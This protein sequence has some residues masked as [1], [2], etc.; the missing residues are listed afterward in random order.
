MQYGCSLSS[1]AVPRIIAQV[2][3]WKHDT[4]QSGVGLLGLIG[5]NPLALPTSPPS[6]LYTHPYHG[7][8]CKLYQ[9]LHFFPFLSSTNAPPPW[10]PPSELHVRTRRTPHHASRVGRLRSRRHRHRPSGLSQCDATP[11]TLGAWSGARSRSVAVEP[12]AIVIRRYDTGTP[13]PR[14]VHAFRCAHD[15]RSRFARLQYPPR[16]LPCNAP[17]ISRRAAPGVR[18]LLNSAVRD[19]QPDPTVPGGPSVTLASGEVLYAEVIIGADGVKSAV[20]KAVTGVDDTSMPTGDAAYRVIIPTDLILQD[21]PS[22]PTCRTPEMTGWMAPRRHVV[23]YNIVSAISISLWSL[24]LL[25][26]KVDLM[27][28]SARRKCFNFY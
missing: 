20:Q 24:P 3:A 6:T 11:T 23:A 25:E 18:I 26:A 16:G 17:S 13:H 22:A 28:C 4:A 15:R 21:P 27:L 10:H 5:L 1:S 7:C 14:R 9:Y 8:A 19:I 12:T 2:G